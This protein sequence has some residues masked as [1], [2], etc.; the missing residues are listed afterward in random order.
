MLRFT[1]ARAISNCL[2]VLN[3]YMV[4]YTL[5]I[6]RFGIYE[7]VLLQSLYHGGLPL[8]TPD[9]LLS[10]PSKVCAMRLGGTRTY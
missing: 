10:E 2:H 3:F 1:G 8:V 5:Y 7:I 6:L 9:M 4:W